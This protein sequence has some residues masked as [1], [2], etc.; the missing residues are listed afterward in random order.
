M[1]KRLKEIDLWSLRSGK[2]RI[3]YEIDE[4]REEVRIHAIGHRKKIYRKL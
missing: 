2:Y 4:K 1:E 3:I